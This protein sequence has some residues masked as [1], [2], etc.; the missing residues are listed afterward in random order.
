MPLVVSLYT[1]RISFQMIYS[2]AAAATTAFSAFNTLLSSHSV[3]PK[4][5]RFGT[6][7]ISQPNSTT[8]NGTFETSDENA[9]KA[10]AAALQ[11]T[12]TTNRTSLMV[13]CDRGNVP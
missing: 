13:S 6:V 7:G 11:T 1:W 9:A 12:G 4:S 8:I 10:F 3:S 5:G 2:T